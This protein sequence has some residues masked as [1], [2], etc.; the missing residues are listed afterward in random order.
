VTARAL[1]TFAALMDAV[2]APRAPLP[3]IEPGAAP[4]YLDR[5]LTASPRLNA[6]GMVAA[7]LALDALPL[8]LGSSRRFRA[9][10]GDERRAVLA[11]VERS[12][13]RPVLQA[14]RGLAHL[15]YYGEDRAALVLGYDADAVLARAAAARGAH[16]EGM[17]G[18][19]PP[20][21]GVRSPLNRM[22]H[23]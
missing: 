4:A 10:G 21:S 22:G 3:A 20:P 15:A 13:A 6:A 1:D 16:P 9:L 17:N 18:Y 11:R 5:L 7:L 14:L 2:V 12:P 8:A 19:S 23:A